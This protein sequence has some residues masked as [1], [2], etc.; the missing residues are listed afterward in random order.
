MHDDVSSSSEKFPRLLLGMAMLFWGYM[1]NHLWLAGV[2]AVLLELAPLVKMRWNFSEKSYYSAWALGMAAFLLM[3]FLTWMDG[4]RSESIR[5]LISL[6]PLFLMAV[7]FTVSYGFSQRVP[8][9]TFSY[10]SRR[11]MLDDRKNGIVTEPILISFTPV[12]FIACILFA[13]N[14]DVARRQQYIYL[15]G[16]F[17]FAAWY[18]FATRP[19]FVS[20]G[21]YIGVLVISLL[22]AYGA[23]YGMEKIYDN[24]F[25]TRYGK[26][27]VQNGDDWSE[28]F[29]N[30]G[31][32]EPI[33]LSNK[34]HWRIKNENGH[35]PNLLR[36]ASYNVYQANGAVWKYMTASDTTHEEDFSSLSFPGLTKEQTKEMLSKPL[37]EDRASYRSTQPIPKESQERN[38]LPRF[39]LRGEVSKQ[40]L[41]PMPGDLFTT[42]VDAQD[43]EVNSM[44]SIRILPKHAVINTTIR[45]QGEFDSE[46][47]PN[48][49]YDTLIPPQEKELLK[50]IATELNLYGKSATEAAAIL[51]TYFS[52]N[53]RYTAKPL[54]LVSGIKKNALRNFLLDWKK[55]HC[56]YFASATT[57]LMREIGIPARY[58][59]GYAVFP[60]LAPEIII[61]GKNAHAWARVWDEKSQRWINV[62]TTPPDWFAAVSPALTWQE[63]FIDRWQ[64][65]REDFT[66][67]R[68]DPENQ[69]LVR[70]IFSTIALLILAWIARKLW[71]SR[72]LHQH[73][74][75]KPNKNSSPLYALDALL[76]KKIGARPS[77][78]PYSLWVSRLK[79]ASPLMDEIIHLHN[80][81]R[82]NPRSNKDQSTQAL[83]EKCSA[84]KKLL[85]NEKKYCQNP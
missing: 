63:R 72:T 71:K 46:K 75:Q 10:F 33:K 62:D 61:R 9:N 81:L 64:K 37:T 12:F 65:I 7:Q 32:L 78:M 26:S 38:D 51:Q 27:R 77:S 66:V 52:N 56:E 82:Y 6:F 35:R 60:S 21:K 45:W 53:F 4:I 14:G 49:Q 43:I 34:I 19:R 3:A 17:L 39:T 42:Y 22:A 83:A 13:A 70:M 58:S 73:D 41:L 25:H 44:G 16:A 67:W 1:V 28:S 23:Q 48:A 20:I 68:T 69:S 36:T 8:L 79:I 74:A 18:L 47:A 50:R 15:Y 59:T 76:T 84:L 31:A 30:I 2:C 29:T 55:G 40:S 85:K 24:Y 80:S 11:K 54:L 5:R 57:L